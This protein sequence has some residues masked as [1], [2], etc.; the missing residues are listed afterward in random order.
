MIDRITT[1][2]TMMKFHLIMTG[3][4][5]LLIIPTMIWWSTSILWI[6][7]ISLY[8]NI[9]GHFS[10]WQAVRAEMAIKEVSE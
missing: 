7:L 8:A 1:P 10:A 3:V 5:I 2:Q 4:W 9:I 6:L